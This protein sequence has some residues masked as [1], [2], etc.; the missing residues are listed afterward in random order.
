MTRE[1][2]DEEQ[3]AEA[4]S[5]SNTPR[6]PGRRGRWRSR[7]PTAGPA[8]SRP[9]GRAARLLLLQAAAPPRT[10]TAG[11]VSAWGV[12]QGL[13]EVEE[14][15]LPD[16]QRRHLLHLGPQLRRRLLALALARRRLGGE[17]HRHG[18]GPTLVAHRHAADDLGAEGRP[19]RGVLAH[20]LPR[21]VRVAAAA[22]DDLD[23]AGV[24]GVAGEV[25][26][27]VAAVLEGGL[28][29]E[30]LGGLGPPSVL[31]GAVAV[32]PR[33]LL[34]LEAGQRDEA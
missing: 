33:R 24:V 17:V 21:P 4:A 14:L 1:P 18:V 32:A 7:R 25:K 2:R 23:E 16:A 29:G 20:E 9:A 10:R 12:Q 13:L 30:Q 8:G 31:F 26:G 3:G 6:P 27:D 15:R 11:Q 5:S 19:R 28:P 34:G 22:L